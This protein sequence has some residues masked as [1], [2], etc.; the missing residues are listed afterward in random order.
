MSAKSI[1]AR[2]AIIALLLPLLGALWVS[3][4]ITAE[5]PTE[6]PSPALDPKASSDGLETAVLAG[7]CFWGVQAVFQ[8][9]K[10]VK[11]ALSGYSGG[12]KAASYYE[13]ATGRTG[14]AEAVQVKFD[15]KEISYGEILHIF[16]SV[17]HDPTQL[18]RQ[19]PDEGPQY[20][21]A[22]FYRNAAQ[23]RVAQAYIQQLDKAG[24]FKAPI[25]TRARS[26][27]RVLPG[28]GLPPGLPDPS[29]E[30]SLHRLQRPA[31]GR[32]PEA[33]VLVDLP[34]RSGDGGRVHQIALSEGALRRRNLRYA[35]CE[36][37]ASPLYK[38]TRRPA[39]F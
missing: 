24:V 2:T 21:S 29:P 32:E 36:I 33:V 37:A 6:L 27:H 10:G 23:Q 8:H 11:Q 26:A 28:G 12:T 4:G 5:P 18:D 31:E 35:A 14:H 20:R 25:V 16:F 39:S 13:V 3:R 38:S 15:P 34:E 19:G 7:G 30:Q 22:I 1:S 17:A 9:V